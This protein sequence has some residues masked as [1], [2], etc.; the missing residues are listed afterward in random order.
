MFFMKSAV[1]V[2][3]TNITDVAS[4]SNRPEGCAGRPAGERGSIR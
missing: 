3:V 1:L 4:L 2:I